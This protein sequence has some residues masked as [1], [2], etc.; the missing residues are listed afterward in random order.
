M[1]LRLEKDLKSNRIFLSLKP[2]IYSKDLILAVFIATG[3]HLLA[4]TLFQID[5][6]TFF[7]HETTRAVS[8]VSTEN[9]SLAAGIVDEKQ[10]IQVPSVL[11]ID[12]QS[13]PHVP[14]LLTSVDYEIQYPPFQP[15]LRDI[16]FDNQTALCT[17]RWHFSKGAFHVNSLPELTCE[18]M[19][20]GVFAFRLYGPTIIWLQMLQ[21]TGDLRL[22]REL[23]EAVKRLYVMSLASSGVVEVEFL[24]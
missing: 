24:P 13:S 20:K 2:K 17:S 5:L 18:G 11:Q 15:D 19:R 9:S 16:E 7:S 21:S 12:R 1:S 10:E 3:L 6:G 4:F 23:E 14:F 22:D 8:F